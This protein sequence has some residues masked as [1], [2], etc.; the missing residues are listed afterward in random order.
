MLNIRE[1]TQAAKGR[2]AQA[3]SWVGDSRR[4]MAAAREGSGRAWRWISEPWKGC[5]QRGCGWK[6]RR[7]KA[8]WGD[9]A[10]SADIST[11]HN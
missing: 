6:A 4:R 5:Q 3:A 8:V 7:E 2:D 11:L 9:P 1:L 10:L